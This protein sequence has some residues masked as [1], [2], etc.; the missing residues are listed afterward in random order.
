MTDHQLEG[1]HQ[2]LKVNLMLQSTLVPGAVRAFTVCTENP[3]I[4]PSLPIGVAPRYPPQRMELAAR[5]LN[6][7]SAGHLYF[8][9]SKQISLW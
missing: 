1:V 9:Q 7:A 5:D 3:K 4:Q 6:T 8:N 2:L